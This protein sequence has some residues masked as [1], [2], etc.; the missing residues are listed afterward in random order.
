LAFHLLVLL[1]PAPNFAG[2]FSVCCA[3]RLL[4]LLPME[5]DTWG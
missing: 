4:L 3:A 2:G 1:C 5:V